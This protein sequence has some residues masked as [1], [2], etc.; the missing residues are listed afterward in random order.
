M[1]V[2][3]HATL[4]LAAVGQCEHRSGECLALLQVIFRRFLVYS[5][6]ELVALVVVGVYA[7]LVVS[8]VADGGTDHVALVL[9]SLTVERQ[10][11]L[12]VRSV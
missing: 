1:E 12:T 4:S 2:A 6:K 10:H 8:C 7:Q 3:A 9:T 11:H 5:G